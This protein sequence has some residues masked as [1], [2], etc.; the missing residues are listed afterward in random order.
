MQLQYE[1]TFQELENN[2]IEVI[3][4]EQIK[5]GYA[6]ETIRLYY[7]LE[8]ICNL[9][10]SNYTITELY[11][12]L[13]QFCEYVKTRLGEVEY[14]NTEA[15]YCFVI[16]PKGV[17]YVHESIEENYFLIDFIEKISK[18]DCTL[19]DLLKIFNKY[20]NNVICEKM[21]NGEF[22]Y[23]IYFK[24]QSPDDYKYCIKFESSHAI[25]HRFTKADYENF[26]F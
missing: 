4:E 2:I 26:G 19:D 14:F 5:L 10:G 12:I 20:S 25:Y 8:S 6:S 18:H 24:D 13:D 23:L 1:P 21:N 17:D 16:P 7:P 15:R 22:D 11:D 9:L 3:K